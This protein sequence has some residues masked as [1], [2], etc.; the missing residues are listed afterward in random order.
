M[1]IYC[2]ACLLV[3]F[4]TSCNEKSKVVYLHT[5]QTE[6]IE[7]LAL[8]IDKNTETIEYTYLHQSGSTKNMVL[9]Y[10]PKKDI[11]NIDKDTFLA[12]PK[13]Y[14]TKQYEYKMYQKKDLKSHNRTLVF[15]KKYG[16]LCSTGYKADFL[17][18]KDS[19][20]LPETKMIFKEIILELNKVEK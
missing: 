5:L 15:H 4:L 7:E 20:Q 8:Q 13:K 19:L 11:L 1:K 12:S 6:K 16:L 2:I 9:K 18:F 14:E 3:L 17:F 10:Q